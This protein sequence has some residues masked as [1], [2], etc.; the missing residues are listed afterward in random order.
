MS[1]VIETFNLE[2]FFL[3]N[4]LVEQ[5]INID[6]FEMKRKEFASLRL[7]YNNIFIFVLVFNRK[8]ITHCRK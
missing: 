6:T 4:F 7:Q 2:I 8:T 1:F 3:L 5:K